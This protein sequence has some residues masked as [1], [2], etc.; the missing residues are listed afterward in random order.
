MTPLPLGGRPS[1]APVACSDDPLVGFG[2]DRV[3]LRRGRDQL[4]KI[5]GIGFKI[6][7]AGAY[8]LDTG[9]VFRSRRPDDH[10]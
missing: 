2:D 9:Q 6:E 10:V 5:A 7:C 8:C 4:R 1:D 3:A